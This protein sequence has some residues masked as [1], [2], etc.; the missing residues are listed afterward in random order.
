MLAVQA[1]G[2]GLLL[3]ALAARDLCSSPGPLQLTHNLLVC[4]GNARLG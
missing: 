2:Y 1:S 3:A 4:W